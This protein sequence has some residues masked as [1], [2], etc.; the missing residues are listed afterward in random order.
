[1]TGREGRS[2]ASHRASSA[3][4]IAGMRRS[5]ITRS[6]A[7]FLIMATACSPFSAVYTDTPPSMSEMPSARAFRNASSSST[8]SKFFPPP[9]DVPL[10]CC[11]MMVCMAARLSLQHVAQL[12]VPD[13]HEIPELADGLI[14]DLPDPL[15]RDAELLSDAVERPGILTVKAVA[16]LE[17]AALGH[18][19]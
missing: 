16:H 1:M 18:R 6:M 5:V 10:L 3:P 17:N 7:T 19:E 15:P 2:S 9:T 11:S 8:I 4:S 14:L 13:L 12:D